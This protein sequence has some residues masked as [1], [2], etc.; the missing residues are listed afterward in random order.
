MMIYKLLHFYTSTFREADAI[1]CLLSTSLARSLLCWWVGVRAAETSGKTTSAFARDEELL[2][3][4]EI[5]DPP[6][7]V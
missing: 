5:A 7:Q 4:C 1:S 3:H 6:Q 2:T